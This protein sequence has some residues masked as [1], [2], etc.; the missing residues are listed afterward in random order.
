MMQRF[1]AE[2]G[3]GSEKTCVPTRFIFLFLAVQVYAMLYIFP[4]AAPTPTV[5]VAPA[6]AVL[7]LRSI[8]HLPAASCDAFQASSPS[9]SKLEL[10]RVTVEGPQPAEWL[11]LLA[12]TPEAPLAIEAAM[13]QTESMMAVAYKKIL[14]DSAKWGVALPREAVSEI[15]AASRRYAIIEVGVHGGWFAS[16]AFKFGGHRVIGFDM[17]PWCVAISRC[18]LL[19]NGAAVASPIIFNRYVSHDSATINVSGTSCGGIYSVDNH[20]RGEVAVRPVHLGRFFSEKETVADLNL[21][22]D[23]EV[24]LLKSDTEGFEAVVLETALPLLGRI[25]NILLEVYAVRW[26]PQGIDVS[27][28]LAV[29]EC[30]HAAGMD[31]MIDLPRRDLDYV[32][33]G[34]IDLDVLP[35]GRLHKSWAEWRVQ[36]G[37]IMAQKNGLVNPNLWLRWGSEEAR[38]HVARYGLRDV[39]ACAGPLVWNSNTAP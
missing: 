23:F 35:S 29:F 26:A 36:L 19:V 14:L 2:E 21:D 32:I 16:L 37:F 3:R 18:T 38:K 24:P 34:E 31:E 13:T 8:V 33:P 5:T 20:V 22:A 9:G 11:Y 15:V 27:R 1:D 17:Q 7:T 28:A 30:V 39:A 10:Q 25:H 4:A 12:H 6:P